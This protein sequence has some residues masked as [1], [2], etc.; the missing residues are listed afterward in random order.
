[1]DINNESGY[2]ADKGATINVETESRLL[3]LSDMKVSFE[4]YDDYEHFKNRG[5]ADRNTII[6]LK[7][8][9]RLGISPR[10]WQS[11]SMM[12]NLN[13]STFNYFKHD[14]VFERISEKN[15]KANVRITYEKY[16]QAGFNGTDGQLLAISAPTKA[17]LH[18]DEANSLISRY[19]GK[20]TSYRDGVVIASFDS[21]FP[22]EMDIA[23][24]EFRTMFTMQ[25]PVDGYGMPASYLT[26]L[27]LVCTNGMVGMTSA[28]KTKFQLG[29]DD[30]SVRHVLDRAI[31]SFNNEEGFHAMRDVVELASSSWA[32]LYEFMSLHKAI[33]A[34]ATND[35]WGVDKR[36][37]I[38]KQ[39]NDMAGNMMGLYGVTGF[40]EPSTKRSR[41][42]PVKCTVYDLVNFATEV[43]SHHLT[44][45]RAR[46]RM[47]AWVGDLIT[48]DF[49]LAN[50]TKTA[51]NFADILIEAADES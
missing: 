3:P 35:S 51:P 48:R 6:T 2:L 41:F 43:A 42:L 10:F 45:Q 34:A 8:G 15:K 25:M 28:F 30:S 17:M 16:A 26:L 13:R 31:T 4:K 36:V 50:T 12:F 29:G 5:Q 44:T 38:L 23:G 9:R 33:N 27:R 24:D 1:M 19:G 47:H 40:N 20:K 46:V 22:M 18:M 11:F 7:D 37:R 39:L 14:E 32:S 21:P 49:D